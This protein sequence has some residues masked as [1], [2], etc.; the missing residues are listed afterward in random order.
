MIKRLATDILRNF[1]TFWKGPTAAFEVGR[2][3]PPKIDAAAW[4]P[5]EDWGAWQN[6]TNLCD[7]SLDADNAWRNRVYRAITRELYIPGIGSIGILQVWRYDNKPILG[8]NDLQRIKNDLMGLERTGF[9][10]FPA[11]SALINNGKR[12]LWILPQG[13]DFPVNVNSKPLTFSV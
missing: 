13:A 5:D 1:L 12:T 2:Q 11:D 6:V 7:P 3:T 8:W 4:I 9:E 10:V